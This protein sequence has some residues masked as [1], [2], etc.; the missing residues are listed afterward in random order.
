MLSK[1][2][3]HASNFYFTYY[4]ITS[5]VSLR[6][7]TLDFEIIIFMSFVYIRTFC[8]RDSTGAF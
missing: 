4:S 8:L 3:M 2:G 5:V 1:G 7:C 6:L